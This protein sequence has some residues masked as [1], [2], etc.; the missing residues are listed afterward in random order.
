MYHPE[1][2][3]HLCIIDITG[4]SAK[5]SAEVFG[6]FI[7]ETLTEHLLGYD[8][9]TFNIKYNEKNRKFLCYVNFNAVEKAKN[10]VEL[11]QN[12]QFEGATFESKYHDQNEPPKDWIRCT[13]QAVELIAGKYSGTENCLTNKKIMFEDVK[14]NR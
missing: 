13:N 11:F 3:L 8:K 14:K 7:K 12:M 2:P 6:R 4:A 1:M 9:K 5:H 10:A